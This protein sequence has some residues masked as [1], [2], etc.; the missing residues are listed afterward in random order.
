MQRV[1]ESI[2]HYIGSALTADS[3]EE[4]NKHR[5]SKRACSSATSEGDEN[6]QSHFDIGTTSKALPCEEL[7]VTAHSAIT[8]SG[9]LPLDGYL[10][11]LPRETSMR[12]VI[13]FDNVLMDSAAN[14]RRSITGSATSSVST[15]TTDSN[16]I[17]IQADVAP[18][19][20]D[21]Q[22]SAAFSDTIA[23]RRRDSPPAHPR[24][25]MGDFRRDTGLLIPLRSQDP[26]N[27]TDESVDSQT[28]IR[29]PWW[30]G[31]DEVDTDSVK[32]QIRKNNFARISYQ[33][34]PGG[35]PS[36]GRKRNIQRNRTIG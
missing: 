12:P 23:D 34:Q 10:K 4:E 8:S 30:Y 3:A 18:S 35:K 25:S 20:W 24:W 26:L 31:L 15:S 9:A 32:F 21:D 16:G 36:G 27:K 5:V 11:G 19:R 14:A 7:G 29:S 28:K 1:F 33:R 22:R 6:L 17:G 13:V 2:F